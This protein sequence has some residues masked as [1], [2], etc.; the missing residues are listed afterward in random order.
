MVSDKDI[1][2]KI[3]EAAPGDTWDDVLAA[4]KVVIGRLNSRDDDKTVAAL[5]EVVGRVDAVFTRGVSETADSI[6][7]QI[8]ERFKLIPPAVGNEVARLADAALVIAEGRGYARG[9]ADGGTGAAASAPEV[10]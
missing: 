6:R 7:Q 2:A 10:T 4:V 3:R 8:N 9:Y 1:A 5:Q